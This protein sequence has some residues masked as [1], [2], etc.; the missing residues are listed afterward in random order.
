MQDGRTDKNAVLGY[1]TESGIHGTMYYISVVVPRK[2][3]LLGLSGRLKSI[4]KHW[5]KGNLAEKGFK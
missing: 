2:G 1:G 3:A 5:N 4:V